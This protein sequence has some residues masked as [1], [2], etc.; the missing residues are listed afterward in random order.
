[1]PSIQVD[2]SICN[3][4][5]LCVRVCPTNNITLGE[6]GFPVSMDNCISCGQCQAVCPTDAV[7]LHGVAPQALELSDPKSVGFDAL[8]KVIKSRRSIREFKDDPI[9]PQQLKKL[10][11]VV[12][13]AP[14]GGNR[15]SV[16]WV[17]VEKK[18]TMKEVLRLA[19]EWARGSKDLSFLATAYDKGQDRIL[20]GAPHLA[21]A[22][23]GSTYGSARL[24]SAIAA[25][26]LE[27]LAHTSGIGTCWAGF[28]LTAM[29]DHANPLYG[30]LGIPSDHQVGAALM[31]GFPRLRYRRV[32]Q[33]KP[34]QMKSV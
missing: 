3:K 34:I 7:T 17:F 6:D 24:D 5:G 10:M 16:E 22:H 21:I 30:L 8:A 28:F 12:R 26:T 29:A 20:R 2:T 27:L 25:T 33:R 19:A 18:E 15:Q 1:M 11:E 31:M 13:F 14:T 9:P 32:P 4:D 23:T